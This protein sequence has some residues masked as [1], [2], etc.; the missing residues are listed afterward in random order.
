MNLARVRPTIGLGEPAMDLRVVAYEPFSLARTVAHASFH[1]FLLWKR[2][3]VFFSV[4][5]SQDRE[6]LRESGLTEVYGYPRIAR[7]K[8][9]RQE[10]TH[11]PCIEWILRGEHGK[12][13][14]PGFPRQCPLVKWQSDRA[15]RGHKWRKNCRSFVLGTCRAMRLRSLPMSR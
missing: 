12:G 1:G 14:A 11:P 13:G 10:S 15:R 3:G 6:V 4:K 9:R 5:G 2:N 7:N 8:N